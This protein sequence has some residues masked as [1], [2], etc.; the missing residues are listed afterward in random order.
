[1]VVVRS[2]GG[3]KDRMATARVLLHERSELVKQL[4]VR[5]DE[6]ETDSSHHFARPEAR[7]AFHRDV[8]VDSSLAVPGLPGDVLV[9]V[10]DAQG[11]ERASRDAVALCEKGRRSVKRKY[12]RAHVGEL[13][14]RH[15]VRRELRAH[16]YILQVCDVEHVQHGAVPA[17]AFG[18]VRRGGV[19][20]GRIELT[21]HLELVDALL[22]F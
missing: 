12:F 2:G 20:L 7:P 19:R 8:R 14:E 6:A 13:N 9:L 10:R 4:L 11:I 1:M 22:V 3:L 18:D 21:P 5:Q 15:V 16:R 17:Y